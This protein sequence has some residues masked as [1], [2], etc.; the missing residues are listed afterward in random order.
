MKQ[1]TVSAH[2]FS[3]SIRSTSV[4]VPATQRS[5]IA[6]AKGVVE[7]VELFASGWRR[8][9]QGHRNAHWLQRSREIPD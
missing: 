7:V 2:L 3:S 6:W 1:R 9:I 8:N 4:S 5:D